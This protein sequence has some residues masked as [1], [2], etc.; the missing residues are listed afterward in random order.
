MMAVGT[1]QTY[2]NLIEMDYIKLVKEEDAEIKH[3][4]EEIH[5]LKIKAYYAQKERERY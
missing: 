2:L 4:K 1:L 5:K 3:S